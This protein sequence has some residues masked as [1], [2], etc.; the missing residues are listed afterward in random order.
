MVREKEGIRCK[1]CERTKHYWR[2]SHWQCSECTFRTTLKSGTMM[3]HS[4]I[5]FIK[6]NAAIAFMSFSKKGILATEIQRQ[7]VHK[8]NFQTAND[9]IFLCVEKELESWLI[10]DEKALK[11]FFIKDTYCTNT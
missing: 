6:W 5:P 3:E 4:K 8:W 9:I 1:K 10:A 7:L 11:N 2:Q